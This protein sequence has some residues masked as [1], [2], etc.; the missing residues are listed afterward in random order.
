VLTF[1]YNTGLDDSISRL[2]SISDRS[3]SL[4]SYAYLGLATVVG[5][6][7]PQ[8][9]VALS[10][11]VGVG[12]AG[13][14]YGGLDRFGRI[15]Y[16]FWTAGA[17]NLDMFQYVDQHGGNAGLRCQWQY[18]DRSG[19]QHPDLRCLEPAGGRQVGR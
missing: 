5:E 14:P 6:F 19:W 17:N 7:Y 3:S 4:V 18:D 12:D 9:G 2:S 10:Y 13:D 15:A 11:L 8:P 1:N 16:Q